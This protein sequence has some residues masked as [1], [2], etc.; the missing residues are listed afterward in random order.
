MQSDLIVEDVIARLARGT[1][2]QAWL[3]EVDP[4]HRDWMACGITWHDE[5]RIRAAIEAR[6]AG[7]EER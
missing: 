7:A 6:I 4:V 1:P 3:W 2:M 5:Q